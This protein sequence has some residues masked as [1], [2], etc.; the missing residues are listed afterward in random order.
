VLVPKQDL[1]KS[2]ASLAPEAI[3][4]DRLQPAMGPTV[5]QEELEILPE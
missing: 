5:E 2:L 3:R 1:S 4:K